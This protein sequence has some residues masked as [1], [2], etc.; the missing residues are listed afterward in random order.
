MYNFYE[1][2]I[3]F[4]CFVFKCKFKLSLRRIY[5]SSKCTHEYIM[6]F[7]YVV[8]CSMFRSMT[9]FFLEKGTALLL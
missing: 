4:F 8:V 5:Y 9:K 2:C 1:S 3:V 7:G 6:K